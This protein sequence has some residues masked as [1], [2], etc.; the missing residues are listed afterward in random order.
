M[1]EPREGAPFRRMV[2]GLLDAAASADLQV[3]A[4]L[5][6]RLGSDVCGMFIEDA[7][8]I[9]WASSPLGRHFSRDLGASLPP[10]ADDL[11]RNLSAVA[12]IARRRLAKVAADLGLMA[13]FET[14][15]ADEPTANLDSF[16]E[17]DL[18][19]VIEPVDP[20]ARLSYP[21]AGILRAVS[22]AHASVLYVPHGAVERAG[23]VLAAIEA[24]DRRLELLVDSVARL[25]GEELVRVPALDDSA[26]AAT[27]PA[28]RL[29]VLSRR[30]AGGKRGPL[31][32]SLT[33]RKV[34]IMIVGAPKSEQAELMPVESKPARPG[35]S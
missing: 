24:G 33:E 5:A 15:R 11:A 1:A 10:S 27:R 35:G 3:A 16:R 14:S 25:L 12:T 17:G 13:A 8:L 31:T 32:A 28:E 6:Q 7:S 26:L 9:E 22:A 19:T 34:P 29:L 21:F 18:I 30:L 4:R 20:L 23:P 2:I